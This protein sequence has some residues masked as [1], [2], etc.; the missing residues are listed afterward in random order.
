M[1]DAAAVRGKAVAF[2]NPT[3]LVAMYGQQWLRQQSLEPGKDYE[4]KGAR[5]DMGV[6]G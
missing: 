5:T 3:S 6:S 2:A 1:A 4:V